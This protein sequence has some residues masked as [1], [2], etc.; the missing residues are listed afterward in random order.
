M[1]IVADFSSGQTVTYTKSV[2][3]HDKGQKLIVTG[4]DLPETYEIHISNSKDGGLAS[5][6]M[7]NPDG[8][9]I[10]DV[11][12]TSGEYVYIWLY[13]TQKEKISLK[14]YEHQ[15]ESGGEEND[16]EG[17]YPSDLP[18]PGE[19]IVDSGQTTYEVR[20]PVIKR[21]AQL[22]IRIISQEPNT[23]GYIVDENNTLIP[24]R[25]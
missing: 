4:I 22:P 20:I 11:Y 5:A 24:V 6:Y 23:V 19:I 14:F 10:P 25:Q 13:I 16:G 18:K 8:I 12:F 9:L 3:Q 15:G 2:Y 1:A 17:E 7:G 21:A